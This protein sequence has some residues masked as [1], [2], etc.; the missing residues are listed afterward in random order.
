MN[1]KPTRLERL[2][3]KNEWLRQLTIGTITYNSDPTTVYERG[4]ILWPPNS[5]YRRGQEYMQ[6]YRYSTIRLHV[7][8][9]DKINLTILLLFN[10]FR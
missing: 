8:N 7:V 1:H 9:S 10:M 6:L 3:N 2:L 4:K 5:I